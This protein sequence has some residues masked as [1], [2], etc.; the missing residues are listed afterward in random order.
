MT[1]F[2][3]WKTRCPEK[4]THFFFVRDCYFA[5]KEKNLVSRMEVPLARIGK[6]GPT[7]GE[8]GFHFRETGDDLFSDGLRLKVT[9]LP[10]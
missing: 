2:P 4:G 3:E 1:L 5:N 9:I 8:T 10:T 6:P 7:L